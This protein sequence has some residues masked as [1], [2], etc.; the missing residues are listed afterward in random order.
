[1]RSDLRVCSSKASPSISGSAAKSLLRSQFT[2]LAAHGFGSP[3]T[4]RVLRADEH[5][6]R[7][8]AGRRRRA[9]S[10]AAANAAAAERR[11]GCREI[12]RDHEARAA[13]FGKRAQ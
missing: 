7:A 6:Q 9:D 8:V 12:G 2:N 13:A 5:E 1:M 11:F 4:K 3:V 10:V